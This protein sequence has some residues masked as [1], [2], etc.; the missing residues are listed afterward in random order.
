MGMN[1]EVF[2]TSTMALNLEL[3][4]CYY[5][6]QGW[7]VLFLH[8]V[9]LSMYQTRLDTVFQYKR[10]VLFREVNYETWACHFMSHKYT[11]YGYE[12]CVYQYM[13]STL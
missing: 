5:V 13:P 2:L 3:L 1:Y 10:H 4:T 8:A 7:R 12:T 6:M 9:R 11:G